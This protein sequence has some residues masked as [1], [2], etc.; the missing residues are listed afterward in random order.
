MP[1]PS[2]R[3]RSRSPLTRTEDSLFE[4]HTRNVGTRRGGRQ[5]RARTRGIHRRLLQ[6]LRE[7]IL[8]FLQL[9]VS[10]QQQLGLN[11]RLQQID[12]RLTYLDNNWVEDKEVVLPNLRDWLGELPAERRVEL[13]QVEIE[14]DSGVETLREDSEPESEQSGDS[15]PFGDPFLRERWRRLRADPQ[16]FREIESEVLRGGPVSASVQNLPAHLRTGS[17]VGATSIS[18]G[19]A[20]SSSSG[21][22]RPPEPKG[23]PPSWKPPEPAGPPPSRRPPEPK[24]PPPSRVAEPKSKP[25]PKRSL[26]LSSKAASK[27]APLVE[28]PRSS[29]A[30]A[31]RDA[32]SSSSV[33]G[34]T[35]VIESEPE[36][37]SGSAIPLNLHLSQPIGRLPFG[38][39]VDRLN[40]RLNKL[41]IL[42]IDYHRVLDSVQLSGRN[43]LRNTDQGELHPRVQLV[44]EAIIGNPFQTLVLSYCHAE[45]TRSKVR[46]ACFNKHFLN[47]AAISD[48]PVGPLGKLAVLRQII[49]SEALGSGR[50]YHLDDSDEVLSELRDYSQ[51]VPIGIRVRG[52]RNFREA[53]GVQYHNCVFDAI[54]YVLRLEHQREHR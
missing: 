19:Q 9:C 25:V 20:A 40:F 4:A 41:P 1:P 29:Q 14:S 28:R 44:L 32:E 30:L 18:P 52:K 34:P 10:V 46:A 16:R 11:T 53:P 26:P 38:A 35:I 37:S 39:E 24:G 2:D 6:A 13:H 3:D 31:I 7:R 15:N 54:E 21:S 12:Q 22:R 23:P 51:V 33:P 45:Y 43:T 42:S 8:T 27:A 50:T 48:K 17:R 5:A 36:P 47:A 49:G